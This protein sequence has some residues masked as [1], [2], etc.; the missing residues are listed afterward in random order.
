MAKL[1]PAE[2]YYLSEQISWWHSVP[3]GDGYVTRGRKPNLEE[4]SLW[5]F[6][7]DLTN[8]TVLDIGCND[9]GFLVAALQRGARRAVGIDSTYTPGLRLLLENEVYPIEFLQMDLFSNEF[10]DLPT[11]D[12]VLFAGVL[13]HLKNPLAGLERL[14]RVT[15]E[16]AL[17][18]TQVHELNSDL[19]T[20]VYYEND[21]LNHDPSNWW[22]PNRKC[23]EA[24]LRT[25]GFC[26]IQVTHEAVIDGAG[27][28][29]C[30]AAP[31]RTPAAET[32]DQVAQS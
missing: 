11:F 7:T 32:T 12:F 29:A 24:M 5:Q 13:Y 18:E 2:L 21:E 28:L 10:L 8:K 23:V 3:L 4:L 20:M 19:P 31:L 30:L 14:R 6:P 15:G 26:N 9:G 25:A 16:Q 22:G 1:T 27:R 17:I